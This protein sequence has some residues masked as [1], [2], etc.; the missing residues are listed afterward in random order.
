MTSLR[1]ANLQKIRN[2]EKRYAVTPSLPA[3]FISPQQMKKYAEV[4]EKYKLTMK[5]TSAQR[6]MMIG[7]KEEEVEPIWADL[8]MN[9]AMSS[10]TCVRSVK[11]CPGTTFCKRGRQDSVKVGI[12]LDKRYGGV[13]M[14]HKMKMGISG[15]PN[16]CAESIV[17]DIGLV[18]HNEGW[19]L[20]VGGNAGGNPRIGDL[21]AEN[22]SD[23]DAYKLIDIVIVYYKRFADLERLGDLIERVGFASFQAAVMTEFTG[24]AFAPKAD[25]KSDA[26]PA[27]SEQSNA[28]TKLAF[29]PQGGKVTLPL[30]GDSI[31]GDIITEYPHTVPVFRSFGMGCLGCNAAGN[32]PIHKACDIHGMEM[33]PLLA[34]LNS[35]FRSKGK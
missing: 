16:S 28:P 21:L 3:G 2:G 25:K 5:V 32:E 4:A 27:S 8:G 22:L 15:C 34:A 17:R 1:G 31:I 26:K 29:A 19:K 9:P 35:S 20:Y 13:E 12:E 33:A 24:Q 11:T 6:I 10:P 23:D 7:M 14:P 30:T 18:G